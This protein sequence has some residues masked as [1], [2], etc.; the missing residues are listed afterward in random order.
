MLAQMRQPYRAAPVARLYVYA[1][2]RTN[3]Q[4]AR[5]SLFQR[6]SPTRGW[7]RAERSGNETQFAFCGLA[8]DA[9]QFGGNTV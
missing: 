2:K 4:M 3:G 9:P 5:F 1:G 6:K 8:D 7:D